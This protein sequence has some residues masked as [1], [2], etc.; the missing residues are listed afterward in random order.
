M[1]IESSDRLHA[2]QGRSTARVRLDG[3]TGSVTVYLKRHR[4]LPWVHRVAALLYPS[5]TF[6]P[7][8]AEWSNL[9]RAEGLGVPVPEAIAAGE[10]I[11]PGVHLESYLLVRELS[12]CLE[13]HVALPMWE[14]KLTTEQFLQLKRNLIVRMA[15]IVAQLHRAHLFHKDL[16]LCHFFAMAEPQDPEQPEITLIDLHRLQRHRLSAARW[17]LKD[18][19]QL[20]YSTLTVESVTN[21]DR[22]RFWK[23]YRKALGIRFEMAWRNAIMK[24]AGLYGRQNAP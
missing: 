18:L 15:E 4:R 9:K 3:P 6:S 13:L 7:G 14:Y 12:G 22:L 20:L 17:R 19:G 5:G 10:R 21:R 1:E 24:K 11:G 23:H 2:K 8:V 16:Y